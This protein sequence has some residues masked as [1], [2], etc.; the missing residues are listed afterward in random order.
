MATVQDQ[1]L[2]FYISQ[3]VNIN[4]LSEDFRTKIILIL[5]RVKKEVSEKL[6]LSDLTKFNKKKLTQIQNAINLTLNYSFEDIKTLSSDYLTEFAGIENKF[7]NSTFN[8]VLGTTYFATYL[9]ESALKELADNSLIRGAVNAEWWSRMSV[10]LQ[11]GFMDQIRLGLLQGETLQQI[12][13]RIRGKSTGKYTSYID[14]SGNLKRWY[15]YKGGIMDITTR[16]AQSLARTALMTV[17][18]RMRLEMFNKYLGVIKGKQ[19]SSILDA[20]T[21]VHCMTYDG[22]TWTLEDVPVGHSLVYV[23]LPAHWNCRSMWIPWLMKYSEIDK[24]IRT[25][26]PEEMDG[27]VSGRPKYEDWFKSQ[28]KDFQKEVLGIGKYKIWTEKGLTFKNLIDPRGNALT[29]KELKLKYN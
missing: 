26:F 9:N 24:R 17:S 8:K 27:T 13:Q 7:V 25:Q 22:S 14:A 29:L 21:T 11:N 6:L 16:E 12:V 23:G 5:E 18:N 4:R 20:R 28:S 15:E 1:L 2:D 3:A 10:V 19:Q